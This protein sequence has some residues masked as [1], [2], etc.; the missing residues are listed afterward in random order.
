[1]N[2]GRLLASNVF[3]PFGLLFSRRASS[4]AAEGKYLEAEPLL[5]SGYQGMKQREDQMPPRSKSLLG[6][7]ALRLVHLCESTGRP[8]QSAQLKREATQWYREAVVALKKEVES[9]NPDLLRALAWL[10]ATC[11]DPEVRDG[12]VAVTMAERAVQM[13]KNEDMRHGF[14]DILAAA[15]AEAGDFEKAI[16]AEKKALALVYDLGY[17]A[18][19]KL[20]E[21]RTPHREP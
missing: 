17:L 15:Y 6:N 1:M 8:E 14:L 2:P 11:R 5:L 19:L 10:L 20:Y 13:N 12:H 7:A 18:R 21:S 4:I 3:Q 9:G 16:A